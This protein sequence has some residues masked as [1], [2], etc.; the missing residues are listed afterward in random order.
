M[1]ETVVA[2]LT[3]GAILIGA[4]TG[5]WLVSSVMRSPG[6]EQL[7]KL[8]KRA[9]LYALMGVGFALPYVILGV[10]QLYRTLTAAPGES[11]DPAAVEQIRSFGMAVAMNC[12]FTALAMTLPLTLAFVLVAWRARR[13]QT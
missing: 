4:V 11:V 10:L 1:A 8:R 5:G 6:A 13:P 9:R 3:W 7:L 12:F 2:A